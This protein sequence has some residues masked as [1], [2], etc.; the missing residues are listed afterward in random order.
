MARQPL[1][2]LG[3]PEDIVRVAASLAS[4]DT[5]NLTETTLCLDGGQLGLD[6]AM[7]ALPAAPRE[8]VAAV[9]VN[10]H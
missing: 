3:A 9:P 4:D 8:M 5:S 6:C 1:G 2:R 10:L 7:V